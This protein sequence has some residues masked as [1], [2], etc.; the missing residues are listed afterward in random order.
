MTRAIPVIVERA[1]EIHLVAEKE[2]LIGEVM[3]YG[4]KRVLGL[5]V[6]NDE[7][8]AVIRADR[9]KFFPILGGDKCDH[10]NEDGECLGHEAAP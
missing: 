4:A 7:A 10:Q 1:T 2:W 6:G 8:V 3:R 9:R 5:D